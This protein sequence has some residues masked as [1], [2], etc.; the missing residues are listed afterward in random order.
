MGC[1]VKDKPSWEQQVRA[2]D[3]FLAPAADLRETAARPDAKEVLKPIPGY[4]S[5]AFGPDSHPMAVSELAH[6]L[7][8]RAACTCAY[9]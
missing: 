7:M 2:V 5:I 6:A 8:V 9:D 3:E 4:P 1:R